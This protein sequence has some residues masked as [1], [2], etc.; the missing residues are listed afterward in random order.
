[1]IHD[2]NA[3]QLPTGPMDEDERQCDIVGQGTEGW[4]WNSVLV[5]VVRLRLGSKGQYGP[6]PAQGYHPAERERRERFS[7]LYCVLCVGAPILLVACKRTIVDRRCIIQSNLMC[8]PYSRPK[9]DQ[10]TWWMQK[11]NGNGPNCMRQLRV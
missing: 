1:M 9:H 4:L 8:I 10:P 11:I 3:M 7:P 2:C 5:L 6:W